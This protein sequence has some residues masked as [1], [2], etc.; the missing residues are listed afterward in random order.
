MASS[1]ISSFNSRIQFSVDQA[2]KNAGNSII[3][4]AIDRHNAET[5]GT[6][7]NHKGTGK[8]ANIIDTQNAVKSD[9]KQTAPPSTTNIDMIPK[10]QFGHI[11][12]DISNSVLPYEKLN[13]TPSS[14]DGL[15]DEIEMQIRSLGCEM[16][17]L[18]GKL[19]KLPQV[20][21]ATGCVLFQRFYY[22]KSFIRIPFD[23]TA[24]SCICLASK[25]EEA[26]RR[27]RDIINVFNHIKQ[28]RAGKTIQPV[29]LDT[30]YINLKNQII[31]AER[32]VLK[33]L[34]FCVHV[35]HPHKIIVMYL[36]WLELD[37]FR[38]LL[39]M[40]WNFMNDS[41]RTDVFVRYPPETIAV[42][43]IYLSARKLKVALP[44]K[45]SWFAV[46]A[47]EEDDIKA[48]CYSMICLYNRKKPNQDELEA[49]VDKLRRKQE[50]S[51]R[52][53]RGETSSAHTA[54]NTPNASTPPS[55]SGSPSKDGGD[56]GEKGNNGTHHK[57]EKIEYE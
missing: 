52:A 37:S 41:L 23:I 7:Y 44:Q 36:K 34:G 2:P 29:V 46:L 57:R 56:N 51:R 15:P 20:A 18:A 48:C 9:T 17:Q 43:C 28:I 6:L 19:L 5:Q 22:A 13:Q 35:K 40:S 27:I 21:M 16:I 33:E 38:E 1:N 55:R 42:A 14:N 50:Q 39:Q 45:P 26:P 8:I 24:M 25:I 10:D 54:S 32:R 49:E 12:L 31:K 4:A 11:K 47:V 3:G 30:N 53:A